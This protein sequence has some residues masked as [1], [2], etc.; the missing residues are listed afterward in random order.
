MI[1]NPNFQRNHYSKT[2]TGI[3]KIGHGSIRLL[4]L[5]CYSDRSFY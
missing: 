4:K 1:R 5:I 3:Y 2:S